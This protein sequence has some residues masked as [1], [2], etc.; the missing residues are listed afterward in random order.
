LSALLVLMLLGM[1]AV[2][3]ARG[4]TLGFSADPVL[5]GDTA[6]VRA[7]WIPRAVNVG[8][9]MVRVNVYWSQIAPPDR[10]RGF[11][12]ANPS[13]AGYQWT[14]LDAVVRQLTEHGLSVL[15]NVSSAPTWAEGPHRPPGA[16]AGSWRPSAA[17]FGQFATALATRYDGHYPDP[18]APG[19]TLPRVRDW[20]AWNEPNLSLYLDP[21]WTRT[22]GRWLPASPL[23]YRAL[24]NSFYAAVKHVASSNFVVTAGT[25]P[26]GDPPGHARMAPV[27]FDQNLFCLNRALAP[28]PC[29][30]PP[31]LDA[32]SHHPYG[33]GGPLW[34]ALNA[35][36]VAVPDVYKLTRILHAAQR[37]GHAL[38]RGP[39]Q[40]WVTEISWDS[41]PPDPHGVPIQKQARWLEQSLYV[42][43]RQGVS[44]VLWLLVADEPCVPNCATTFQGGVFFDN[45][46]AKPAAQAFLFPFV[47][48]R[49]SR[50]RI[51]AWGRA[52]QAGTAEIELRR[53]HQWT[54]IRR[55]RV[56][57]RAVFT[58]TISVTGRA[59]LRAVVGGEPSLSWTQAA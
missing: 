16:T 41:D 53:G 24:L 55:V 29:A 59:T 54:T 14:A 52:P 17:A 42:L 28:L 47:T 31:H 2:A 7:L 45:G 3:S 9:Q 23:I 39:K 18:S 8:A 44:T 33:I 51:V 26:Y 57:A 34:H 22:G 49:Q 6:A 46:A 30:D 25:A 19:Q 38:P 37:Y 56:A 21:Q 27:T 12:P 35:D 13:S 5:T 58:T 36:D 15:M 32:L 1:P 4:L 20:Q 40:F 50:S 10:P 48:Q 43:W 11:A